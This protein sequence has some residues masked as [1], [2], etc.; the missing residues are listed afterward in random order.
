MVAGFAGFM[1]IDQQ[2]LVIDSD[3]NQ[4]SLFEFRQP[5]IFSYIQREIPRLY[6]TDIDFCL[7]ASDF[8]YGTK[9]DPIPWKRLRISPRDLRS[10]INNG[11]CCD[12][13]HCEHRK[14]A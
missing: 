2:I 4:I 3:L 1:H 6:L 12:E 7:V 10:G 13:T 14:S 9:H 5:L 8:L 11:Y